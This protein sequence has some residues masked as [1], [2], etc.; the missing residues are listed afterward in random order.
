M[1]FVEWCAAEE[2]TLISS[3][4]CIA[5]VGLYYVCFTTSNSV[6][7]IWKIMGTAWVL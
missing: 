3:E 5:M 6:T 7:S 2:S 4:I 1:M